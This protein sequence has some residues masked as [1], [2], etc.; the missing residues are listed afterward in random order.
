MLRIFAACVLLLAA[1]TVQAAPELGYYDPV[2]RV[3]RPL[4]QANQVGAQAAPQAAPVLRYGTVVIKALL[5][6]DPAIPT[7]QTIKVIGSVALADASYSGS[8]GNQTNAVRSGNSGQATIT[9]NYNFASETTGATVTVRCVVST[10]LAGAPLVELRQKIPLPAN[11]VTT[12][13]IFRAG[14]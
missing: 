13:V 4:P 9:L 11:G 10:T 12:T 2:T 8:V 14:V 6:V 1:D 3:F 5:Y 7:G